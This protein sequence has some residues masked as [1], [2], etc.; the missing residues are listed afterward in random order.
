MW[1]WA[2][3]A[4]ISIQALVFPGSLVWVGERA[5]GP[6]GLGLEQSSPMARVQ[7]WAR[8]VCQGGKNQR[9]TQEDCRMWP[10]WRAA[11]GLESR[12]WLS[13]TALEPLAT[14]GNFITEMWQ[15]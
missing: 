7:E 14:C 11:V 2:F 4:L 12:G 8:W 3:F 1:V 10:V 9:K 13:R 6:H 5:A 15:V